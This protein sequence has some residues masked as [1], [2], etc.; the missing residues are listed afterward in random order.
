MKVSVAV[1]SAGVLALKE[2]SEELVG[3][4]MGQADKL[5]YPTIFLNNLE[6]Y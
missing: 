5:G 1:Y 4:P 2:R 6:A 3:S